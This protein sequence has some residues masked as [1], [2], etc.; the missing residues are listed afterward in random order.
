MRSLRRKASCREP[1][2]TFFDEV[3]VL[4]PGNPP[5]TRYRRELLSRLRAVLTRYFDLRELAGQAD[6]RST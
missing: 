1:V 6:R 3:L 4:D 2:A 5:A